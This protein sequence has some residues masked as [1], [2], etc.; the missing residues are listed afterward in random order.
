MKHF[1]RRKFIF[2]FIVTAIGLFL[3]SFAQAQEESYRIEYTDVFGKLRRPAVDF[4]H[5]AHAAALEDSGCGACHHA[6]D[7]KTG[8]LVYVED[9]EVSCSE[10]HGRKEDDTTPALREA[11]H[12]S[13]TACHRKMIKEKDDFKGPTTCGECHVP[14]KDPTRQ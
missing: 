9:E 12:G 1:N 4:A 11:F 8:K 5:E 10:C 6:P 7:E 14:E 2:F 13:C 3:F